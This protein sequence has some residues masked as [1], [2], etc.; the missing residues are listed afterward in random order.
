MSAQNGILDEDYGTNL[1][2]TQLDEQ[3]LT[4]E[5]KLARFSKTSEFQK[6]KE[7]L[8]ERIAFYQ[9]Y[10]P[11]GRAAVSLRPSELGEMWIVANAVIGEFQAVLGAYEQARLAVEEQDAQRTR[12]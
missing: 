3:A 5:R 8:E 7:H 2:E 10:L 4:V 1:P 12:A 11:D 9:G 6:L